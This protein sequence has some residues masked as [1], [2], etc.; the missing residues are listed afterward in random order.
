MSICDLKIILL[1]VTRLK[2]QQKHLTKTNNALTI[3]PEVIH[4]KGFILRG[5]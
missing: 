3:C 1:S 5:A 4:V 2:S